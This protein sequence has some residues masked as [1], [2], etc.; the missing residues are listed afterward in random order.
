MTTN[1]AR[2]FDLIAF[3]VDG[4]LVGHADGKVVWNLFNDRYAR[5][6]PEAADRMAR[7]LAG[8]LSYASWVDLDIGDWVAAGATRAE[9][10]ATIRAELYVVP[11]VHET[12]AQ[13]SAQGY[14]IAV[15]S[16]TLDLT[17]QVLLP[18]VRFDAQ[19]TNRID[20]DEQGHITGWEATPY[21]MEGKAVALRRIAEE[22]EV[23]LART[24]YVGDNIND[25]A[26]M[27]TAG[28]AV[29]FEPKA[30]SVTAAASVVIEGDLRRL[31]EVLG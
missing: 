10:A 28:L 31:L 19:F 2:T 16:G 6:V 3:D 7:Y 21:D 14:R 23:Q 13:L 20:F 30:P 11:G 27:G 4:T 1:G 8:Q 26:A 5:D 12:L 9:L 22:M 29:A 24:V 17:L 18:D 25:V 15:I